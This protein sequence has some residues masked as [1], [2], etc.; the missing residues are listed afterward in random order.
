MTVRSLPPT[1]FTAKVFTANVFAATAFA[2]CLLATAPAQASTYS[3]T[4]FPYTDS[5][6]LTVSFDATDSNGDGLITGYTGTGTSPN[7]VTALS[8]AFSGN[9]L[10]PAFS[11]STSFPA[12]PASADLVGV[13]YQ[14]LYVLDGSGSG[15][16]GIGFPA[17]TGDG[18]LNLTGFVYDPTYGTNASVQIIGSTCGGF[19]GAVSL[20]AYGDPSICADL[21]YTVPNTSEGATADTP[22]VFQATDYSTVPEPASLALLGT[23]LLGIG[24]LGR[25][26]LRRRHVA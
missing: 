13:G 24:L 17:A 7:E 25:V 20:T 9:S 5:A 2:A 22:P 8:V 14:L 1:A 26:R 11:S 4:F 6:S 12:I 21:N 18:G 23:G 15:V 10:I 19:G 16:P 3:F